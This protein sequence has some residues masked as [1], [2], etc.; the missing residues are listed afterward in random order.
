MPTAREKLLE[1]SSLP[2]GNTARDHLLSASQ[3]SGTIGGNVFVGC[4]LEIELARGIELEMQDSLSMNWNFEIKLD[5]ENMSNI[6]IN[7]SGL[8][9][10]L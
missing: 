2:S 1:I 3:G 6:D 8:E 7:K 10:C 9:V 5:F 4:P